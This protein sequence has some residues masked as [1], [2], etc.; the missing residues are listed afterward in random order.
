MVF[1]RSD[2]EEESAQL[3]E[4]A[5]GVFARQ[6]PGFLANLRAGTSGEAP[7]GTITSIHNKVISSIPNFRQQNKPT[8]YFLK[9]RSEKPA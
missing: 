1:D 7:A 4:A 2:S 6:D 8:L 9:N 5:W 3:D